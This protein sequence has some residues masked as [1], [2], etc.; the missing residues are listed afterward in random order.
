MTRKLVYTT[1]SDSI[2]QV[3]KKMMEEDT[4]SLVVID[5][6]NIPIG[7]VTERD[8]VRKACSREKFNPNSLKVSEIMSSPLV[9]IGAKATSEEAAELFLKNKIRHLLVIDESTGKAVGTITPMDFTR[10]R[11]HIR[12]EGQVGKSNEDATIAKILD[13]YRD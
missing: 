12:T 10:Y 11:E 7:I 3:S 8:I 5:I 2:Q 6:N 9:T 1:M 13:Y 4:S